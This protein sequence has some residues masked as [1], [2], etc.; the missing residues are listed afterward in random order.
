[1]DP[2]GIPDSAIGSQRLQ[3]R[4]WPHRTYLIVY[5]GIGV[6]ISRTCAL[7]ERD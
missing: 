4:W 1:M 7:R 6:N 5:V 3:G 2:D